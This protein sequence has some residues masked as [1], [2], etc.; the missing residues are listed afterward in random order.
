MPRKHF[1]MLL[2]ASMMMAWA[3]VAA[4][5]C[6]P[7][8]CKDPNLGVSRRCTDCKPKDDELLARLNPTQLPYPVRK[9][10]EKCADQIH[11]SD[12]RNF[13]TKQALRDCTN[14]DQGLDSDTKQA[15]VVLINRSNLM[16]QVDLDNYH[17]LCLSGMTDT[18][19][20]P[21]PPPVMPAG[22]DNPTIPPPAPAVVSPPPPAPAAVQPPT[23]QPTG[24]N[25]SALPPPPPPSPS[26][27]PLM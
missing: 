8:I 10:V 25:P 2:P 23:S 27:A 17:S 19:S 26:A 22:T 11:A 6:K 18:V 20:T 3:L 13:V 16:E 15:L 21:P 7:D 5:G 9:S 1:T 4:P 24:L 12:P 14:A